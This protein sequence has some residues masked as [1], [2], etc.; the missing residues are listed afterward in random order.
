MVPFVYAN[1]ELTLILNGKSVLVTQDHPMI[2][3]IKKELPTATVERMLDLLDVNKVVDN[4]VSNA[5]DRA[6]VKDGQVYL[7][8]K[9]VH[10][11]VTQR[12]MDFIS[13]GLPISSLLKFLERVSANPSFTAQQELFDFL[14]NKKLPL[15]EDGC[16][17]AYKAV[18]PDWMDKYEHKYRN[19]PGDKPSMPRC[20]VDDDRTNECSRGLHV[21]TIEYVY[22]YGNPGSGDHIIVV[23]VDPA[24]VVAVPKDYNFQKL[25]TW[26]YEV[27]NEFEGELPGHLYNNT[28]DQ[29]LDDDESWLDELDNDYEYDEY[30][31]EDDDNNEE[32]GQ[33]FQSVLGVRPNGQHYHNKR[34]DLG[35]FA[36]K[37]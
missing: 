20:E 29:A 9:A 31:E 8:G 26:T 25:R 34:D 21:G 30:D 33:P 27:M 32:L 24:D 6:L 7:D 2:N 3:I 36:R 10:S 17:I 11:T 18:G 22:T 1:G 12:I 37:E 16:F 4:Y 23:K 19:K 14:Q 13:A 35:R 5:G 28:V 15:T